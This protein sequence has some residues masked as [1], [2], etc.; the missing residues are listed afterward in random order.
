MWQKNS[1][2]HRFFT[3][4]ANIALWSRLG[5]GNRAARNYLIFHFINRASRYKFLVITNLTHFFM[6]LFIYFM[7]LN[8]SSVTALI[9]RRSNRI[10]TSSGMINLCKWL[11]GMSVRREQFPLDRH[12]KQSLTQ[13]NH[14][15]WCINTIQ[16]PDDERCDARNI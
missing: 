1:N 9:I 11:L 3:L 15:R 2:F 10:N 12:T 13:T 16:S 14:T 5:Y 6:Y 8:V 4:E 7:S